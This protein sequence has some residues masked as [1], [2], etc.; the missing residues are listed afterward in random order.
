MKGSE[1]VH[2]ESRGWTTFFYWLRQRAAAQIV[3]ASSHSRW[4]RV[5]G[6]W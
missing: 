3:V 6:T 1:V 4:Q 2:T 5:D